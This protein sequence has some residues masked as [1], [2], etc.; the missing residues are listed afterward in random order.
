MHIGR[1]ST[2]KIN[3]NGWEALF[4]AASLRLKEE[5]GEELEK[6]IRA[7]EISGY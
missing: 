2:W 7:Q 6:P 3:Q 5:Q 4:M 1:L